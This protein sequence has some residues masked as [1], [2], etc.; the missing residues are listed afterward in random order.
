MSPFAGLITSQLIFEL[1]DVTKFVML[2]APCFVELIRLCPQSKRGLLL[3]SY[4]SARCKHIRCFADFSEKSIFWFSIGEQINEIR[5][6]SIYVFIVFNFPFTQI[7]TISS[8]FKTHSSATKRFD[9][10]T[11]VLTF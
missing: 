11:S 4:V 9:K 2:E 3:L 6:A 1:C 5:K 10:I 8:S 7:C